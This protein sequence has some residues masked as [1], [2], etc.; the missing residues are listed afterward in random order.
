MMINKIDPKNKIVLLFH[1][2]GGYITTTY[3][4]KY[5]IAKIS[6]YIDIGGIPI[7]FYQ[8]LRNLVKKS[9]PF[10]HDNLVQNA[11]F[12][13][14]QY[15]KNSSNSPTIPLSNKYHLINFMKFA[16]MDYLHNMF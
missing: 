3:I 15:R 4:H 9:L 2:F 6:G 5:G 10:D 16:T 11:S 7:T 12:I 14:Q 1:S 8:I 13:Q